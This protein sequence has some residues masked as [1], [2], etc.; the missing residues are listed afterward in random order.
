MVGGFSFF[1][2]FL[3]DAWCGLI[4]MIIAL[5]TWKWGMVMMRKRSRS[6]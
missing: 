2:S 5:E 1:D 3:A 4:I 6:V